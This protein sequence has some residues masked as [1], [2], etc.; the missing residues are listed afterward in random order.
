MAR[1]KSRFPTELE[2]IILK[3]L[4]KNGA[5]PVRGVRS[6]LEKEANRPLA[7]TSVVT[8]MNTMVEKEYLSKVMHGN[9]YIFE[10]AVE[11]KEVSL[12]ILD[13]VLNRVFNGSAKSLV[14]SLLESES[15]SQDEYE[16][17]EAL[18]RKE[19]ENEEKS[20]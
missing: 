8:T 5:M 1:P 18:I 17:L 12:G 10:S 19:K 2:L 7:H 13:D 4:W 15:V 16:K 20:R 9:S 14:L 3:I 11:E 6:L